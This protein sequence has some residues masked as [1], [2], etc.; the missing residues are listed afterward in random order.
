MTAAADPYEV[1]LRNGRRLKVVDPPSFP[2]FWHLLAD[3]KWEPH[4]I[5]VI[6][7]TVRPESVFVDIGGWIGPTALVAAA[8]GGIV[9]SF[10]PDPAALKAF[11]RHL[12]LNPELADRIHL[13]DYA[14]GGSNGTATISAPALGDSRSSFK[15]TK[16]EHTQVQVRAAGEIA[17]E[18]WFENAALVK[19]DVE[20]GEYDLMR[21]LAPGLRK[22]RPPLLL[23]THIDY[24]HDMVPTRPL[25]KR[26]ALKVLRVTTHARLFYDLR[27]YGDWF[28]P[29]GG[30]WRRL[31]AVR[32]PAVLA[33]YR[34][35]EFLLRR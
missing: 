30:D 25:Y 34:N 18:P 11:R 9:H 15:R 1:E 32:V 29:S 14:L 4:P 6:E 26:R 17:M 28:R 35:Q 12:A 2:G 22:R 7:T 20:G 19:V 10:E 24:I 27:F 33:M 3:G 16:G 23:S 8:F 13:H 5:N 21:H 31:P